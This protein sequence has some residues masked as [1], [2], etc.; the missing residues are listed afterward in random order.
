MAELPAYARNNPLY[1]GPSLIHGWLP[2]TMQVLAALAVM[3]GLYRRPRGWLRVWVPGAVLCGVGVGAVAY[4][5]IT[6]QGMADNPPPLLLWVWIGV[7]AVA[8][9]VLIVGWLHTRWLRRGA[10]MLAVPL[11]LLAAATVL[12]QWIDYYDTLR[13][14]WAAVTAGPLPDEADLNAVRDLKGKGV[15]TTGRVVPVEISADVS[16]FTHRTEYVYLPPAWFARPAPPE[17]PAVVMI[18]GAWSTPADWLRQG[19]IAGAMDRFAQNHDGVT[20]VLVFADTGGTFNNDTE[21]VNGPRGNVADHITKEVV[22]Y[23]N[24]EFGTSTGPDNWGVVGWSMGGTCAADLTITH[25]DLFHAFVDM[26]GDLT[27]NAGTR[28]QTVERLYGGDEKQWAL[29]DTLSVIHDHGRY[30]DVAGWLDVS[31]T[32]KIRAGQEQL[33]GP[34]AASRLCDAALQAGIECAVVRRAGNHDWAY[35]QEAFAQA[36]P[37]IA[38][39]LG[40]PGVDRLPLPPASS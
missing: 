32:A 35:A 3:A 28:E 37:W 2:V 34:I 25:P 38:G 16:G 29:F 7:A 19:D 22:P 23:V 18:S 8:L 26:A 33:T 5:Y 1:A 13:L 12:N 11:C 30:R 27:P 40:S 31:T 21:C 39:R 20:P 36:F 17:L 15:T 24:S 14:A 4:W 9:V 10:M 6:S